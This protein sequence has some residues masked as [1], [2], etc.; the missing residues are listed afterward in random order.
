M[1]QSG[2]NSS[3]TVKKNISARK[4]KKK[5]ETNKDF[6]EKKKPTKALVIILSLL[7]HPFIYISTYR[8]IRRSLIIIVID[9]FLSFSRY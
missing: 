9:E 4:K 7:T 6:V 3:S 8:L 5:D 1:K 2:E